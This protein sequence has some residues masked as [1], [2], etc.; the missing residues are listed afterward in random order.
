MRRR[1]HETLTSCCTTQRSGGEW[2][3]EIPPTPLLNKVF[4]IL[5]K[6]KNTLF[7]VFFTLNKV[8]KNN[9]VKIVLIQ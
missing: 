5:F 1:S 8:K 4:F 3:S 7:K 6:V 2:Q 9:Q